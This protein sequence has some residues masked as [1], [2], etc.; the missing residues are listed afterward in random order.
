MRSLLHPGPVHPVR[1]DS[2]A[3]EARRLAYSVRPGVS[4]LEGLTAP[5]TAAGFTAATLRFSN[6]NVNPFRYVMPAA[7]PDASHVAYFSA[8]RAPIGITR[9]KHA[10]ATFG[11]HLGQP[12]LHCH[13]EWIEPDGQRRGGHILNDE[14]ILA[15]E[16]AV[17]AWGFDTIRLATA[18]DP[19]TNF[20]LFQAS[21]ETC[22]GSNAILARVRPNVDIVS[23]IETIC[24]THDIASAEVV[25]SVGSLVGTRFEDGRD[26]SDHATEVLIT[27]G[28]ISEGRATIDAIAVDMSGRAHTGRLARGENPVCIT[29]DLFL[30][31]TAPR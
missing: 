28:E 3:G 24:R 9:I 31:R 20:T 1:I 14:T 30:V 7:S 16:I 27:R 10:N 19:E 22:P 13:A 2:F 29:F 5:L 21:G 12:F 6:L 26:I 25:G 18:L 8:P 23:A 4:L 11:F 15:S 17:D